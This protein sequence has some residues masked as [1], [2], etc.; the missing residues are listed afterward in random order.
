MTVRQS[1]LFGENSEIQ[2][3]R[4]GIGSIAG[5]CAFFIYPCVSYLAML[6]GGALVEKGYLVAMI[7]FSPLVLALF[8]FRKFKSFAISVLMFII[9]LTSAFGYFLFESNLRALIAK[10]TKFYSEH[11]VLPTYSEN[12]HAGLT[13]AS[14]G[15]FEYEIS[16]PKIW[17]IELKTNILN[18][19]INYSSPDNE[20]ASLVFTCFNPNK[21][22]ADIPTLVSKIKPNSSRDTGFNVQPECYRSQSDLNVC[23]MQ[24][25]LQ[26]NA[27][28]WNLYLLDDLAAH[29][30]KISVKTT[31]TSYAFKTQLAKSLS[32]IKLRST[33]GSIGECQGVSR[34]IDFPSS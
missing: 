5:F 34:M 23:L 31:S 11:S 8:F 25:Q 15:N 32:S 3:L 1:R 33:D 17:S 18:S 29:G 7:S 26:N 9:F 12:E 27:Q 21:K 6:L 19:K 14:I 16:S 22:D 4:M 24:Q 10:N 13:V 2:H 20:T 30:L 28:I